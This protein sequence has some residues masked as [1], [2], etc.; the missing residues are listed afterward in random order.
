MAGHY[1]QRYN[2]PEARA[3]EL[4]R[5]KEK[6]WRLTRDERRDRKRELIIRLGGE[7]V[8]CGY[9][10]SAA[11]LDF[12]HRDRKEK[13][14]T[15][16]SLLAANGCLA[17]GLNAFQEAIKEAAKCDLLCSNCHR[18]ETYPDYDLYPPKIILPEADF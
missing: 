7:C 9:N 5:G 12:H 2:T 15:V 11:G 14:R 1:K 10:K 3:A 4:A 13:V 8:R 6:Y 16:S 17:N 18:E